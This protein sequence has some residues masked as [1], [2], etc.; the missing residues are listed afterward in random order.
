M[1]QQQQG[2]RSRPG[3]LAGPPAGP[4]F[5]II[6][7]DPK[8]PGALAHA[9]GTTAFA[10][11]GAAGTVIAGARHPHMHRTDTVDYAVVLQGSPGGAAISPPAAAAQSWPPPGN[12][13]T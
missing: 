1:Q 7:F 11:M 9:D 6:Q 3:Q 4:V 2:T 10:A 12:A 8:D 5:R 13:G